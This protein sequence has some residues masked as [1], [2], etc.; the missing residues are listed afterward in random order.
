MYNILNFLYVNAYICNN[1]TC[2]TSREI[3][4]LRAGLFPC[5]G[6]RIALALTD[7]S[8]PFSRITYDE[9]LLRRISYPTLTGF[10]CPV[11]CVKN[12]TDKR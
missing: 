4:A 7:E 9:P 10:F 11:Y 6:K 2:Y 5:K 3:C 8:Q 12:K 1:S